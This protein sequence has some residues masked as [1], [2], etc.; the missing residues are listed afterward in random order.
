VERRRD[1]RA[2][3]AVREVRV[4]ADRGLLADEAAADVWAE[5]EAADEVRPRRVPLSITAVEVPEVRVVLAEV[6]AAVVRAGEVVAA[7]PE[8]RAGEVCDEARTPLAPRAIEPRAIATRAR[9]GVRRNPRTIRWVKVSALL[10]ASV[11]K[12]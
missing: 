7:V 8:A 11:Q 1:G 2:G 5:V 6:L 10:S 12:R 4:E 9:L 3:V